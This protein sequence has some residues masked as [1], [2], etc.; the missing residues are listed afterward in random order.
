MFLLRTVHWMELLGKHEKE[1]FYD[2]IAAKPR[3]WNIYFEEEPAK[4]T[5]LSILKRSLC[6]S[7][8]PSSP[9]KRY[10]PLGLRVRSHQC[11]C[12]HLLWLPNPCSRIG[13]LE[14]NTHSRQ[15]C[16]ETYGR[17]LSLQHI[18]PDTRRNRVASWTERDR[19]VACWVTCK[20]RGGPLLSCPYIWSASHIFACV[21]VGS[22]WLSARLWYGEMAIEPSGG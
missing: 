9:Q 1:F 22:C 2:S 19:R 13:V 21:Y 16:S 3:F 5:T 14:T 4:R 10:R 12:H 15:D 20:L 8:R 7:K 6:R 18:S 17:S 11:L